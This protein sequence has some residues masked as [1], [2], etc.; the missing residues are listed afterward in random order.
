GRNAEKPDFKQSRQLIYI[1]MNKK[2]NQILAKLE[3][4]EEN[5][6]GQLQGGFASLSAGSTVK[7][8][9]LIKN[10]NCKTACTN[11]CHGG[12]CSTSCGTVMA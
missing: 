8:N 1:K 12:N 7:A 11:N 4:I 6:Q 5:Q 10:G 2:L 3:Q 9:S